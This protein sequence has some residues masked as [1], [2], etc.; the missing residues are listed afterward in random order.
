ME[1]NVGSIAINYAIQAIAYITPLAV[2][3]WKF[4]KADSKIKENEK[5]IKAMQDTVR[6]NEKLTARVEAMEKALECEKGRSERLEKTVNE[7]RGDVREVSTKIDIILNY[8]VEKQD[9]KT[10]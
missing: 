4:S 7:L 10:N 8:Q 3:I 9:G 5:D 1:N 2:L 6:D